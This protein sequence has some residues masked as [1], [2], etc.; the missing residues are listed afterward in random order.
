MREIG[1]YE[2]RTRLAKLLKRV[3]E[4][5]RFIITKYGRAVAELAPVRQKSESDVRR[6]ITCGR[7]AMSSRGAAC[8]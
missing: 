4:G 2:A 7:F 5:E 1:A 8:A 3:E 6:A